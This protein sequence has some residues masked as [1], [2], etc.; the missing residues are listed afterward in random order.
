MNYKEEKVM[1]YNL[2]DL[3]ERNAAAELKKIYV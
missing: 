3:T 2:I 1:K